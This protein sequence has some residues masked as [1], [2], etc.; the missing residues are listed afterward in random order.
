MDS[1]R[2]PKQ[3]LFGE[4]PSKSPS[5]SAKKR[6]RDAV[7]NDM[8]NMNVF[9]AHWSTLAQVRTK[10][11]VVVKDCLPTIEIANLQTQQHTALNAKQKETI[12]RCVCGRSFRRETEHDILIS[13]QCQHSDSHLLSFSLVFAPAGKRYHYFEGPLTLM[14][15]FKNAEI[16][17]YMIPLTSAYTL[18][19]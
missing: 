12:Y 6:W 4:L 11:K 17:G 16:T 1:T 14:H 13:V 18:H 10:W 15:K 9:E 3:I 19:Y 2:S 8:K 5:H 7:S